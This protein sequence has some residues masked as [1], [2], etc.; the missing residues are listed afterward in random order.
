MADKEQNEIKV[1]VFDLNGTFYTKSS[2]EEFFKFISKK[3]PHKLAYYFQM[4]YYKVLL[5]I[6]QIRMTE[7][8]ENFFNYLNNI[9]PEQVEQYAWEFWQQEYPNE[10]NKEIK[11]KLDKYKQEGVQVICATGALEVYVKPLF[12]LYP[13]DLYFGTQTMYDGE[14][15]IVEGK[16]CKDE[17]KIKRLDKHFNG[18]PYRIVEAY[19]DNKENILDE[20]DRAWL[21]KDDGKLVRL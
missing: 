21:V 7:F 15:Y 14:T 5:K 20:A 13:V 8:K 4:V 12:E 1:V 16:A 17:E 2:K 3:K 19:S 11:A 6:H 18:K 10:F 9:P